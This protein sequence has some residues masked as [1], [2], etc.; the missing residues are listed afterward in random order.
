VKLYRI[1]RYVQVALS[2]TVQV[3]DHV[4]QDGAVE[5]AYDNGQPWVRGYES[6]VD[7]EVER[8]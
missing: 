7:L 4:D 8:L 6:L 3:E 2:K 1:T 5:I